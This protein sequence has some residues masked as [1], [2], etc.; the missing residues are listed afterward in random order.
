MICEMLCDIPCLWTW[1]TGYMPQVMANAMPAAMPVMHGGSRG[2]I[3]KYPPMTM[4]NAP[5]QQHVYQQPLQQ[6]VP[7]ATQPVLNPLMIALHSF[8]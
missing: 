1:L 5:Q 3:Y 6:H 8:G 2:N 4:H 7:P